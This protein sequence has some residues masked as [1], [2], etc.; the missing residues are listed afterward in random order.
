MDFNK[1]NYYAEFIQEEVDFY[2]KEANFDSRERILFLLRNNKVS[3]EEA[4][5][6]M[7]C[8]VSTVNRI[9]RT[10]KKKIIKTSVGYYRGISKTWK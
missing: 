10:M 2:L 5:E 9:N 7:D 8:S 1:R 3:L 6:K 4:A